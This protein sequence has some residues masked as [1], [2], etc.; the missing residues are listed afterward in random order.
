MKKLLFLITLFALANTLKAGTIVVQNTNDNGV[1]SLRDA[2]SNAVN[3]DTIRFNPNLILSGSDTVKLTSEIAFNKS[4]VFKGLYNSTDTLSISGEDS[5]RIFNLGAN[6]NKNVVLDSM[7]LIKGNSSSNGGAIHFLN[8]ELTILNSSISNC[9]AKGGGAIYVN[10][11]WN[12]TPTVSITIHNSSLN[13]NIASDTAFGG[14]AISAYCSDFFQNVPLLNLDISNSDLSNNVSAGSGGAINSIMFQNQGDSCDITITLTNCTIKNNSASKDGGGI[15]TASSIINSNG[16]RGRNIN[17]TLL[18]SSII[19]NQAL[20]VGGGITNSCV[21][22]SSPDTVVDFHLNVTNS[23]IT[24][25][26][27]FNGGGIA[28]YGSGTNTLNHVSLTN[29][30]VTNNTANN[31]GGGIFYYT[32]R[33][34]YLNLDIHNSEISY[35]NSN[36]GGGIFAYLS[37]NNN[38][39]DTNYIIATISNSNVSNNNAI[40]GNGG[41]ISLFGIAT[42]PTQFLFYSLDVFNSTINKNSSIGSGAGISATLGPSNNLQGVQNITIDKSTISENNSGTFA[43]GLEFNAPFQYTANTIISNSTIYNNGFLKTDDNNMSLSN[44]IIANSIPGETA[45]ASQ[46]VNSLGYN[47]FSDSSVNGSIASDF[48]NVTPLQLKLDTLTNNGGVNL[49]HAPLCG[50]IAIDA[51]NPSDISDAQ[52][53]P[54]NGIRRDI[55]A[56]DYVDMIDTSLTVLGCD[57]IS[58][59]GTTYYNDTIIYTVYTSTFG[60]DS[61]V[62]TPIEIN[63]P[64]TI[65]ETIVACDS[66]EVR[67]N[68]YYTTQV[69]VDTFASQVTGCDSILSTTLLINLSDTIIHPIISGCDSIFYNWDAYFVDTLM[70]TITP[71]GASNGCALY[72]FQQIYVDTVNNGTSLNNLIITS[73]QNGATYQWIDCTNGD[74]A[75]TGETNQSFTATSNGD[76]AV[77]VTNGYCIDTSSCVTIATVGLNSL[78][79]T[80]FSIYPNPTNDFFTIDFGTKSNTSYNISIIDAIGKTVK[81]VSTNNQIQTIDLSSYQNGVYF[82]RV[83]EAFIRIIKQ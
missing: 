1:G 40:A 13:N 61:A 80:K 31:D 23:Q 14:G 48:L 28:N 21:N 63:A 24:G 51:G 82:V 2:I 32:E 55:G 59:M 8:G 41:G 6:I 64:F 33:N 20:E 78:S 46:T 68:W 18:N 7:V 76:Y 70:E 30:T 5:V 81:Q 60:C 3:G 34:R 44:T 42:H 72:E 52:N 79:Q 47:I 69:I 53:G 62:Y 26:T 37:D 75:I 15:A 77:I 12:G 56:A 29:S 17:V 71:G 16:L 73:N 66:F 4:I 57:S 36:N 10:T 43:L 67:G 39:A 74:T 65:G 49:T 38:S 11:P 25:N 35:N 19:N 9:T 50:S 54:I 22:N 83:K 58:F 45:L 27:G